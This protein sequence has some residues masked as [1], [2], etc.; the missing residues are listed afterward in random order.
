MMIFYTS[1]CP[2][3]KILRIYIYFQKFYFALTFALK[4][5][6]EKNITLFA[7]DFYQNVDNNTIC[8]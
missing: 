2:L 3:F 6:F 7:L 4:G 8:I 5:T 1:F